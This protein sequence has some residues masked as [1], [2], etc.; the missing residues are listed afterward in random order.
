MTVPRLTLSA[1]VAAGAGAAFAAVSPVPPAEDLDVATHPEP[2]S[3]PDCSTRAGCHR[4]PEVRLTPPT[5]RPTA[6]GVRAVTCIARTDIPAVTDLL[7]EH[8]QHHRAAAWLVPDAS[9]R[10]AILHG[11]IKILVEYALRYGYVDV[12]PELSAAAIW[13]DRTRPLPAPTDRARHLAQASEEDAEAALL[14]A[15]M[16]GHHLPPIPHLQLALLATDDPTTA[17]ALLAHRHQRLDRLGVAAAAHAAT[18]SHLGVLMDAGYQ[19]GEA[20]W[21]PAGPPLW[22]TLR[23]AASTP[24]AC[25]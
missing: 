7:T 23:P 19:P 15:E 3:T 20:I 1:A 6:A 17:A 10:P 4:G 24:P 12:L 16:A 14:L 22:P 9:R 21:L 18:Q 11:W 13:L 2:N 25:D 5:S 8:V